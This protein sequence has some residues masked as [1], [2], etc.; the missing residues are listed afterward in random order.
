MYLMMRGALTLAWEIPNRYIC[1]GW[2]VSWAHSVSAICVCVCLHAA[3]TYECFYL[4]LCVSTGSPHLWE[5]KRAAG[6][7]RWPAPAGSAKHWG[8]T[9]SSLRCSSQVLVSLVGAGGRRGGTPIHRNH[10]HTHNT[11]DLN[12]IL[13]QVNTDICNS[14]TCLCTATTRQKW[15]LAVTITRT[16]TNYTIA[17]QSTTH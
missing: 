5:R 16:M 17:R 9:G 3:H 13:T 14:V 1:D 6:A 7:V 2:E 4:H 10:T 11:V 8:W 15:K 12:C